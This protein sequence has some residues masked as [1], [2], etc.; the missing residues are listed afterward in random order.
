MIN[1]KSCP[2]CHS[3]KSSFIFTSYNIHGHHHYGHQKFK[4][5]E[6]RQC[7]CIF[8]K[9]KIDNNFYK[10][11][12]PQQYNKKSSLLEKIW[13]SLNFYNRNKYLP[14]QGSLLDVGCGQ[15]QYL[16]SLPSRIRA[17]GID[18]STTP[19]SSE[20]IIKDDFFK[21]KFSQKY[22]VIT[23]W[24]SL[25]HFPNPQTAINKA[26]SLLNKNGRI[27]ISIPNTNS[28]AFKLGREK[29]FHLDSPRHLF[30][31]NNINIKKT[32]PNNFILKISYHPLEFPLDLFWSTKNIPLLWLI[33]PLLKLFD[34]ETMLIVASKK[35]NKH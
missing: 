10:K 24:H 35:P 26:V 9:I 25:E 34:K 32:F 13:S 21:H 14:L 30:L 12:Y 6:C 7:K 28:L 19:N 15:G 2:L 29:W 20:N 4:L 18:L 27:L 1:N 17:T 22:D 23:F 16:R 5:Y 11:Y 8:P 3:K 31:P 33:Y